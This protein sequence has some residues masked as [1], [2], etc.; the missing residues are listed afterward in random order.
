MVLERAEVFIREGAM[1]EFL[2]ATEDE[3]ESTIAL[4]EIEA[5]RPF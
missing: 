5:I 3:D 4:V 2:E 1:D